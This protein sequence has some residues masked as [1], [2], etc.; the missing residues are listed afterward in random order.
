MF[1]RLF[2]LLISYTLLYLLTLFI[3]RIFKYAIKNMIR[4]GFLSF[5]SILVV[6][7]MSFFVNILGFLEYSMNSI[8]DT[9]NTRISISVNLK[10]GYTNDHADIKAL[11]ES[12]HTWV[13][14]IQYTYISS[15]K[16]LDLV[17][18][19]DPDLASIVDSEGDN[20]LPNSIRFENIWLAYYERFDAFIRQYKSAIDYDE[21]IMQSKLIDY[22]SQYERIE[23]LVSLIRTIQLWVYAIIGLFLFTV[24]MIVY[25]TIGNFVFFYKDEIKIIELVGGS[26][27]FVYG[28]FG[29]QGALYTSI[30]T[31]LGILLCYWLF[32]Y[33]DFSALTNFPDLPIFFSSFLVYM[34]P[35]FLGELAIFTFLG[36]LSGFLVSH[37][38][39]H[40]V[41][42]M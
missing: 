27:R 15:E 4:S 31:L 9:I 29:L 1:L 34:Q 17:R 10:G 21:W 6:A 28:P 33:S 14:D 22:K 11:L 19:R 3:M 30:G 5:S 38:Y 41:K 40:H 32:E 12:I 39:M 23:S 2:F 20:P 42:T 8:I 37:R 25:N 18:E 36:L 24:F 7:L 35:Y 16:A 26:S 13:P